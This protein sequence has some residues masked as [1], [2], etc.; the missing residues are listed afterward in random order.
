MKKHSETKRR[1]AVP[2]AAKL[3]GHHGPEY[4]T[5]SA[6]D[7]GTEAEVSDTAANDAQP[8]AKDYTAKQLV[9]AFRTGIEVGKRIGHVTGHR[10][11]AEH[12]VAII[13]GQMDRLQRAGRKVGKMKSA[14]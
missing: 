3:N 5:G 10:C 2:G 12:D 14:L 7:A 1:N 11:Q 8:D 6:A 13:R 4:F 9:Q